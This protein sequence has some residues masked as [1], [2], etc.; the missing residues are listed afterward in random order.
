M[1]IRHS[2]TD[3]G[4]TGRSPA[5]VTS[6]GRPAGRPYIRAGERNFHRRHKDAKL[7]WGPGLGLQNCD[8]PG[9]RLNFRAREVNGKI[10]PPRPEIKEVSIMSAVGVAGLAW[11]IR[12]HRQVPIIQVCDD[13]ERSSGRLIV[14]VA[15]VVDGLAV[16]TAR[17]RPDVE[18]RSDL[19]THGLAEKMVN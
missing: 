17:R 14:A 19:R 13:P 15:G 7:A 5:P 3:V 10:L 2:R 11:R 4:A 6:C 16:A 9:S 18:L 8:L 1:K 12:S